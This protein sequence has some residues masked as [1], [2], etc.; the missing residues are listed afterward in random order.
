MGSRPC[1]QEPS[2]IMIYPVIRQQFR[3]R[4]PLQA[5]AASK[6]RQAAACA[7]GAYFPPDEFARASGVEGAVLVA[8]SRT[9]AQASCNHRARCPFQAAFA[10]CLVAPLL[11]HPSPF[12][13]WPPRMHATSR[14][15]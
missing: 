6:L 1:K 4:S 5:V 8:D 10:C 9:D 11:Q 12:W 3:L 2:L 15:N 7:Y 14:P 13:T